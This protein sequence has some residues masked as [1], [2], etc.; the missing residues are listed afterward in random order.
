MVTAYRPFIGWL[1]LSSNGECFDVAGIEIVRHRV[2][3]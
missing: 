3:K 1:V 2:Q